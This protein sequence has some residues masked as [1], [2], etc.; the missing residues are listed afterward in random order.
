MSV[1]VCVVWLDS[2]MAPDRIPRPMA[3]SV[4]FNCGLFGSPPWPP[5]RVGIN[6]WLVQLDRES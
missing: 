4:V 6:E 3:N 5:P 2:K 1:A